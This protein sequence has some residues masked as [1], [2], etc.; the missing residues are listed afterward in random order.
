MAA[1]A[2]TGRYAFPTVTIPAGSDVCE[3]IGPYGDPEPLQL[4]NEGP[5]VAFNARDYAHETDLWLGDIQDSAPT[6]VYTAS[7]PSSTHKVDIWSPQ[8][9]SGKLYWIERVH[10]GSN[11]HT[12]TDSWTVR[13]MDTNTDQVISVARGEV[14][15]EKYVDKIR[16]NGQLLAASVEMPNESWLVELWN[17]NGSVA[18]SIPVLGTVYD[19]A[20]V[21]DGVLFTAGTGDPAHDSIGNMHTYYWSHGAGTANQIGTGAFN[22]AGC[23]GLAT[24]IADPQASLDSTGNPISPR[25]F[26]ATPPF[27]SASALSPE[28]SAS[29]TIGIDEVA[30]GSGTLLWLEQ[31]YGSANGSDVITLWQQG[32]MT[33]LQLATPGFVAG[34]AIN[35]GWVVWFA[36][37]NDIATGWVY[38]MPLQAIPG[39]HG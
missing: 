34:P 27:S 29:G 21:G 20:I 16:W 23:D 1:G 18:A 24:W 30:C 15:T 28:P 7:E 38:G 17:E 4:T 26:Y 19:L 6:I 39:W 8:L 33:P 36:F 11:A 14:A 10:T 2:G 22:V 32:W 37:D 13:M 9:A 12:G 31:E 25:V 3:L 5:L 35:G